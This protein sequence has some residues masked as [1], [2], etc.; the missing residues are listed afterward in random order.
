ME[1]VSEGSQN[2][3]NG[4]SVRVQ[5]ILLAPLETFNLTSGKRFLHKLKII[6]TKLCKYIRWDKAGGGAELI[7]KF[8]KSE[9]VFEAELRG[10]S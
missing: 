8:K 1:K 3:L 7:V 5:L 2:A 6:Q 10:T 4:C 9:P